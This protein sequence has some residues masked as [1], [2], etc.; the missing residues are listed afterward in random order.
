MSEWLQLAGVPG[1]ST[2]FPEKFEYPENP[3]NGQVVYD[4]MA[5]EL[6][7]YCDGKWHSVERHINLG[8]KPHTEKILEWANKKIQ[9]EEQLDALCE[10]YPALKDARTQFEMLKIL[11][12]KTQ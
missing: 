2:F 10:K 5:R 7:A 9:E 1:I 12:T 11:I 6:M 3:H 4:F 8:L